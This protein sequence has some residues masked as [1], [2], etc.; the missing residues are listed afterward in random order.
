M[1][2]AMCLTA[3]SSNGATVFN[4]SYRFAE[5]VWPD[6]YIQEAMTVSGALVGDRVDDHVENVLLLSV[7]FG[8]I[9][10][11][12]PLEVRPGSVVSF[13]ALLNEFEFRDP[14]AYPE[15]QSF[16]SWHF[17]M[18]GFYNGVGAINYT[19]EW[20]NIPMPANYGEAI[21]PS[22]WS[23]TPATPPVEFTG[24]LPPLGGS[25]ATGGGFDNPVRTFKLA[26]TIPV[27]FVG[28]Q[29][30]SPLTSGLHTL[31]AVKWSNPTE[32]APAIDAIARDVA[33]PGN[34]FRC[35]DGRWHFNL[36]VLA[37]GM[38]PG[39][40]QLIATLSDGSRHQVWIRIK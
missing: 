29:A 23:L 26:S 8:D 2:S 15:F 36:D 30:G 1:L 7:F 32:P 31:Q 5:S 22:S 6:G 3:A 37:T 12:G 19:A 16:G 14:S 27:K 38:V 35:D 4:F 34:T 33:T 10:A 9:E 21:V 24:F 39:I 17:D 40:W 13:D 20:W 25:D 18:S 11:P 28:T